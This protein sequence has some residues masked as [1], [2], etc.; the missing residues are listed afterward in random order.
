MVHKT[1]LT[2]CSGLVLSV[3]PLDAP[4]EFSSVETVPLPGELLSLQYPS[5]EPQTDAPVTT[6]EHVNRRATLIV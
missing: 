1:Q 3:L 5:A 4:A 6:E 2:Y